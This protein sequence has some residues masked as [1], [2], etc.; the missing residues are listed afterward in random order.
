MNFIGLCVFF[1]LTEQQEK[2]L[3]LLLVAVCGCVWDQ[4]EGLDDSKA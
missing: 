2:K 1:L 3:F 4:P